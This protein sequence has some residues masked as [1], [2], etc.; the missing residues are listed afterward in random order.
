M[1]E[2]AKPTQRSQ[3]EHQSH[4]SHIDRLFIIKKANILLKEENN[5]TTHQ[6]ASQASSPLAPTPVHYSVPS[7]LARGSVSY[8][9]PPPP[10][11]DFILP[12]IVLVPSPATFPLPFASRVRERR[13]Q[14]ITC[15]GR[16]EK[17]IVQRIEWNVVWTWF[18][19]G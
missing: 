2:K 11:L 3:R 19:A 17:N 16:S 13:Y 5:N 15:Q 1:E 9:H 18:L 12:A 7:K 6:H 14:K 10:P 4:S 8:S